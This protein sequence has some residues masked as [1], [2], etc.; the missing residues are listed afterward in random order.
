MLFPTKNMFLDM[1]FF[2]FRADH[3]VFGAM[4]YKPCK[5]ALRKKIYAT[6]AMK[7]CL[8][9]HENMANVDPGNAYLLGISPHNATPCGI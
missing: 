6:D 7:R 8:G 2:G 5:K 4:L 9:G 1:F 3:V